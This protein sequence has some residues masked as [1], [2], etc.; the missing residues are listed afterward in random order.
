MPTNKNKLVRNQFYNET[1]ISFIS[2]ALK[3]QSDMN[4]VMIIRREIKFNRRNKFIFMSGN[5][6]I[7]SILKIIT[8]PLLFK[9]FVVTL[10]FVLFVNFLKDLIAIS[11]F[12]I[13]QHS[14]ALKKKSLFKMLRYCAKF[15]FQLNWMLWNIYKGC[16]KLEE[17]STNILRFMLA[18]RNKVPLKSFWCNTKFYEKVFLYSCNRSTQGN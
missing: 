3:C 11:A 13:R 7:V 5:E 14:L 12:D 8:F 2:T 4:Y 17:A 16:T 1:F 10:Y 18:E 6:R 15:T 9:T